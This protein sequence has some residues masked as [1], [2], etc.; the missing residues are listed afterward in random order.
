MRAPPRRA[1]GKRS[2]RTVQMKGMN[3]SKIEGGCHCGN[4][5][6]TSEA[7]PL[8]VVNCYCEDCRKSSGGAHSY[9]LVMPAGSVTVTG[10]TAATFVD[11]NG[12][13]GQPLNRHFSANCGTHFRS[14]CAGHQGIEMIK[15]GTLDNPGNFPPVAHIWCEQKPSW[16]QIPADAL[17]FP[18]NP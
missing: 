8:M 5:R 2:K 16:L 11:R 1:W 3:M 18:R 14:E 15:G 9:N 4:I 6:Y 7:D 10:D 13:S 17:R 12:S